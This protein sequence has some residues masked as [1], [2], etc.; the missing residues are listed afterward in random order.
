MYVVPC[1]SPAF[2]LRNNMRLGG[3]VA[4]AFQRA[5][6]LSNGWAP[7]WVD[8][9]N[10][11]KLK[12]S[13]K[14]VERLLKAM[15][16][17]PVAYDVE[18]DGRHPLQCSLRCIAFYDGRKAITV[19]LLYRTGKKDDVTG[20]AEWKSYWGEA[21]LK[22][23]VAA[24]RECFERSSSLRA[25]NG[26]FDRMVV[27]ASLGIAVPFGRPHMD[28]LVCHH[29]IAP[30]LPH[31]LG[32]LSALYTDVKYYKATASG[33][34]WSSDSDHELW[35]YCSR[36][37]ITTWL[38]CEKM[39]DEV[40]EL[41]QH[42]AILEHDLWQEGE[43]QRWR[44]TGIKLDPHA[45]AY[46]RQHYQTVAGKA[47]AAMKAVVQ[48]VLDPNDPALTEL[49]SKLQAKAV[50][51]GRKEDD[52]WDEEDEASVEQLDADG[53]G[54]VAD[55]FNPASLQQLRTLFSKLG[56]PLVEK[57]KTGAL[58]TAK[59]ILTGIRK[60][61]LAKK[62]SADDKRIAFLDYLFAWRESTKV[63]ST[64]LR[65]EVL[66]DGRIHCGFS[67]HGPPTGRLT[68]QNSNLQNQP[69]AVRGMYVADEEHVLC[70]GDADALELRLGAY[71]SGD[72]NYIEVFR[73]YD[74]KTGPKPHH[75]NMSVIFG[76][77]AT[78]EAAEANPGMYV[79]A[80]MFAYAVAYGAGDP[81]IYD[82]V[83]E[84]MPDL[85]FKVFKV[86]IA[87]Y[88]KRYAR[89]F[90][91]Q[92]EVVQQG[93]QKGY[94]D[95]GVLRRRTYFFERVF[96]EHSPEAT[97][98]QN[99]PYQCLTYNSRVLVGTPHER[100]YHRIGDLL[101]A[102]SFSAWTGN[103]W[104]PARVIKKGT[105]PTFEVKLRNGITLTVDATHR[106]LL[107]AGTKH[108]WSRTSELRVG[109]R[110]AL[111]VARAQGH[112][113]TERAD[114]AYLAGFYTGNG[115]GTK[116]SVALIA[117]DS[118]VRHASR[119]PEQLIPRLMK[120]LKGFSPRCDDAAGCT[121]I[122][123]HRAKQAQKFIEQTGID[124]TQKAHTK[125]IP[126]WVWSASLETRCAFL[127]GLLDADG[128]IG[129][130]KEIQLQ[131]CQRELLQ[132]CWLLARTCGVSGSIYG[133]V[134][135]DKLGHEAWVL[136][137]NSAQAFDHLVQWTD[138]RP[139]LKPTQ[140][141]PNWV[142]RE[143]LEG[144]KYKRSTSHQVLASRVRCGG[145]VSPYTLL[146]MGAEHEELY[147]YTEVESITPTGKSEPV[148]TLTVD[149]AS[150]RYVG[151]GVI[152]KNSSGADVVS[153]GNRRM[154]KEVIGPMRKTLL[155]RGA[156]W[157]DKDGTHMLKFDERLEQV[158][159][160]H[161]E[162][163]WL[164]PKRLKLD[165]EVAFKKCIEKEVKP[166]W[167]IPWDIKSKARWKP[168]QSRCGAPAQPEMKKK[169]KV[170]PAKLPCREL[171]D[172]EMTSPHVWEGECKCGNKVKVTVDPK[173]MDVA[174]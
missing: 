50:K 17:R 108:E 133:P 147:D 9:P 30:Y 148:F 19:P 8:E 74:A 63:D 136:I 114:D 33:H 64:Y 126:E 123:L 163:L 106:F 78:K 162:L 37:V 168:V 101:N 21:E 71:N 68:S 77:P 1:I 153:L 92:R 97:A 72:K 86:A 120:M 99:F 149:H 117:G 93:T 88:R 51:K 66:R 105:V 119:K 103:T 150:H 104:A 115:C 143:A 69:A 107:D 152:A 167:Y 58:S 102:Q 5:L 29:V 2:V 137:L 170:I 53:S 121:R 52:E 94:L 90:Q 76:L 145:S 31:N 12:P 91:F 98:M 26:Q 113:G 43:C 160:V 57:T 130:D 134:K 156:K 32:F 67:V 125:R 45:L 35:L 16:G 112:C 164:V 18:T 82:N 165:F 40:T 13:L 140:L 48:S 79:A 61:L 158:A 75:A 135:A 122:S 65:P 46:F 100:G 27:K 49:I 154:M 89:L 7:Q 141:A 161:D 166:G 124:P 83:R 60:D 132:E 73:A 151:E 144:K 128:C 96:D 157:T 85:D 111:D 14:D 20:T 169:G 24:M 54:K 155:K 42:P 110:V 116:T 25:Q 3:T 39:E 55:V 87:N 56:I 109:A 6:K 38:I 129:G 173:Y 34:S 174:A 127:R 118:K 70:S 28:S 139:R 22:R 11:I 138:K 171:V 84:E 59:E 23:I 41:E 47:L 159:Q 36:D 15:H 142:A 81:K 62:V 131:L 95:S 44:E 146:S 10:V 172:I 4:F 80:K